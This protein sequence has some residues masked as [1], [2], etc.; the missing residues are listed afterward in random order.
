VT[1]LPLRL[2]QGD[3][4]RAS[5]FV[6]SHLRRAGTTPTSVMP[7]MVMA[8]V[9]YM[10]GLFVITTAPNYV[11][12]KD[13]AIIKACVL[14]LIAAPPLIAL[15]AWRLRKAD[16]RALQPLRPSP[17]EELSV[18]V[19]AESVRLHTGQLTADFNWSVVNLFVLGPDFAVLWLP[20]M[21]P[22]PLTPSACAKP[23][24]FLDFLR[25]A[26]QYKANNA[27]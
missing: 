14:L 5:E 24:S 25:L 11:D 17:E 13:K 12:G 23:D 20:R 6:L 7:L 26:Q 3:Y 10:A 2:S 8:T 22:L 1:T 9:L 21:A 27:A 4:D 18:S 16:A 15:G 19:T